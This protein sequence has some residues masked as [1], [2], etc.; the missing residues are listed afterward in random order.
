MAVSFTIESVVK[1]ASGVRFRDTQGRELELTGTLAEIRDQIKNQFGDTGI[2]GG[3][4]ALKL[5]I[6]KVL[7]IDPDLLTPANIEGKTIT[8]DLTNNNI[9]RIV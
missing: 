2:M 3:H 5:A 7:A 8:Y 1:T 6:A 9:L 4:N